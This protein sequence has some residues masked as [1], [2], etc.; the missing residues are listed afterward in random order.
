MRSPEDCQV[1]FEKD[2]LCGQSGGLFNDDEKSC[3]NSSQLAVLKE[4]YQPTYFSDG[5]LVYPA[6]PIGWEQQPSQLSG[7]ADRAANFFELAVLR[8]P[9]LNRLD[10]DPYGDKYEGINASVLAL[11]D[12]QKNL[13]ATFDPFLADSLLS[14]TK[15]IS[16]HGLADGQISPYRTR[17]YYEEVEAQAKEALQGKLQD[18]YR[19]Y[20]IPGMS[21]C[22]G[23]VGPW[24]FGGQ[25][26]LDGGNRPLKFDT[27]HDIL[28]SLIAWSEKGKIADYQVGA[29]Y[30]QRT[31]VV[32][33]A[34]KSSDDSTDGSTEDPV[35]PNVFED[36]SYG[37]VNT[38]KLCPLPTKAVYKGGPVNGTE[39]W[40]SFECE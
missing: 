23:G 29:H 32:P 8:A 24:H 18:Y 19:H 36:Y 3:L 14:G 40:K 4:T 7:D 38:R 16:Y 6:Y 31:A 33:E 10:F 39:A 25:S 9:R 11:A 12:A 28:L 13:Y 1:D 15:I 20:E 5:Q 34:S 27:R 22:R 17:A 30:H 35:F 37:I 2:L 26:Q 21:H